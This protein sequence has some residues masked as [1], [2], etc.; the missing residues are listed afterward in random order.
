MWGRDGTAAAVE[1]D[2][3]GALLHH[4][5]QEGEQA[6]VQQISVKELFL[7]L[8]AREPV[9]LLDVRTPGE[10]E[11]AALPGSTLIPLNELTERAEEIDANGDALIVAYC[12]HGVRSLSAAAILEKLGHERVASLQGGIDAWSIHIDESIPR[13]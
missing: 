1:L 12:H 13:Y 3:T 4:S 5:K 6:M 11:I 2:R 8:K 9:Y 7:K 10:H